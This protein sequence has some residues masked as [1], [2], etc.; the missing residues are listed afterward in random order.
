MRIAYL[1]LLL[2]SMMVFACR[3]DGNAM[4]SFV[5]NYFK[6]LFEW[7]PTTA[8]SIGF[9]EY[10]SKLEDFSA[11]AI[12]RRIEKLKELQT[13]LTSARS[14]RLTGDELIDAEILDDQIKAELLD[15]ETLQTWRHNPMNYVGLPGSSVDNLIKRNFAAPVER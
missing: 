14:G 7:T 6:A 4:S 13:G 2:S 10:D 3:S 15:L 11:G 1:V 5:D 12:Q 9:H 8:T